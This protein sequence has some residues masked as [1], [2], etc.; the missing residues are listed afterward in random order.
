S[1]VWRV[2]LFW[3]GMAVVLLAVIG[4]GL[5][6]RARKLHALTE[7]DTIVIAEFD[8]KT[9]DTVFDGTLR[10]SLSLQLEQSP[11]LNLLSDQ[12]ITQT[13]SLMEKPGARLTGELA[14]DV[15]QRTGSA[16]TIEGSI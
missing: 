3:I 4:A 15:C 5:Y 14:R 6:W 13:L 1:P 12:A 11:F 8:N 9:G 16:A 2:R 7:K 10:Q